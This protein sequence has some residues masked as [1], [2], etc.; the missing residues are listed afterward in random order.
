[1]P[2]DVERYV[3]S[4]DGSPAAHTKVPKANPPNGIIMTQY[5]KFGKRVFDIFFVVVSLPVMLPLILILAVLVMLDKKAPFFGHRRVGM[6]GHKFYCWKLRSM[7]P[8]AEER[9]HLHLKSHPE[10]RAEWDANFKLE[11]DPRITRLGSFL[12]RSS[13]DELPQLWNILIGEMS[14]VG[15]RPVTATELDRYGAYLSKYSMMRPGLTGLWQVS[16]RNN[17]SYEE[18]I[19]MDV[20]YVNNCNL[21]LDTSIIMRTVMVVVGYTGK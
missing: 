8:N 12:R 5:R 7:A 18:R 2:K 17:I 6:N 15:P 13:L 4:L 16:G 10:A 9:L 14:I 20:D 11:N 21:A 3:R 1:M 19:L